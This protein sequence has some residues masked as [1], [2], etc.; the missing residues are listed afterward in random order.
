MVRA[1]E[2]SVD[3]LEIIGDPEYVEFKIVAGCH[4]FPV[5]SCDKVAQVITDLCGWL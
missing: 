2:A 4:A 1:E 5:Q 3:L